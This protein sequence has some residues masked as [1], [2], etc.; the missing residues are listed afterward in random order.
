MEA[1]PLTNWWAGNLFSCP[2]CSWCEQHTP[3]IFHSVSLK[4]LSGVMFGRHKGTNH[5]K[6]MKPGMNRESNISTITV[7]CDF[8]VWKKN[9]ISR[10]TTQKHKL[11]FLR[12]HCKHYSVIIVFCFFARM[13]LTLRRDLVRDRV[14]GA[15][16]CKQPN[17]PDPT[18][19]EHPPA[20][21][22]L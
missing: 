6:E 3:I 11:I 8:H 22:H 2:P 5:H 21:H 16:F 7:E 14:T 9:A 17:T 4:M 13:M 10:S 12:F 19:I 1:A 18:H 15:V 20:F